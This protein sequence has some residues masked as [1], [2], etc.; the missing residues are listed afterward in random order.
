VGANQGAS[1]NV[2]SAYIFVK[3]GGGWAGS[4]NEDAKLTASDA[5]A[6]DFF[7][8]SVSISGD[9]AIVGA[10][11]DDDG[12]F[13]SGAAYIFEKP[14]GG[15]AGSLNEDSKLTASDAAINDQLGTSVSISGATVIVGAPVDDGFSGS[16]YVFC[17]NDSDCD[18]IPDEFDECPEDPNKGLVGTQGCGISEVDNLFV[19]NRCSPLADSIPNVLVCISDLVDRVAEL[20]ALVGEKDTLTLD[21]CEDIRN[22]I[23]D[24]IADGKKI[25]PKLQKDADLCDELFP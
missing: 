9:T 15:W 5:A 2:G 25:S 12:G 22:T 8:H 4:L 17:I 23:E 24:K 16:A 3:P 18:G 14:N 6:S 19:N 20:E 1:S 21:E 11:T 10:R 13:D 7:G